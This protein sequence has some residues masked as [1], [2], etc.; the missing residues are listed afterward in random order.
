VHRVVLTAVDA[1]TGSFTTFDASSGVDLVDAV[2]ASCAVPGIWPPVTVGDRRYVDGGVRSSS[3]A[4]LAEGFDHVLVLSPMNP[5]LVA[6]Q[7]EE[8]AALEATGSQVLVIQADEDALA[9]MGDNPLDPAFRAQAV[10]AGL[11]QGAALAA[12]VRDR[13]IAALDR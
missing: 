10:D 5:A 4:H 1:A 9:A 13:W 8:L 2:A 12:V 6:G 3:N 7:G 11:R